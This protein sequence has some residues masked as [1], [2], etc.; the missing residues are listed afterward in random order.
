MASEGARKFSHPEFDGSA[1]LCC[2]GSIPAPRGSEIEILS[3]PEA[4]LNEGVYVLLTNLR[5]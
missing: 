2:V 3:K 1:T 4:S 5:P